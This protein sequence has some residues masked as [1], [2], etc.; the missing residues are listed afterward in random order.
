MKG[1]SDPDIDDLITKTKKYAER[2]TDIVRRL[3]DFAKPGRVEKVDVYEV[4]D[5]SIEMAKD[6]FKKL[7]TNIDI[8]KQMDE[9]IPKVEGNYVHFEEIFL[10]L[11]GNAC[12][13]M[14]GMGGKIIIKGRRENNSVHIDVQDTGPGI[15]KEDLGKV[16]GAFYT[17]KK[18]GMGMGL[19]IIDKIVTTFGGKLELESE[20]NRGS[21]FKVVLPIMG[22]KQL[23]YPT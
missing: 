7:L 16:F 13:A 15:P 3:N 23:H 19:Y 11:I 5:A 14:E 4:V 8:I 1:F 18:D 20:L 12:Q 2:S 9:G 6:G 10:N 17:T 22:S 21:T